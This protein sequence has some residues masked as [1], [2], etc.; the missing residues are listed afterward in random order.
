MGRA[1]RREWLALAVLALPTLLVS[2]DLFVMLLALPRLSADLHAGSTQQLWIMDVYGFMVAGF[3]LT[4]G[5]LGDRTG[6]RR[7]LLIGAAT[8]GAASLL[9]AYATGPEMLIAARALLGFAG[10]A[11]T[12]STLSMV[13]TL[14]GDPRQR[15][16]A[17]GIIVGCFTVGAILG[18]IVGG[19]LL[20]RFWW[21]SVFL[22]GVPVMVLLLVLGPLLLP[23]YRDAA[24]GRL[25][26]PSVA[27]SLA[28]IFPVVYGLKELARGGWQPAPVA[29]I[30]VGLAIGAV[31]V[32]RQL[33]LA[34]P[35]LD[36]RLFTN[37]AFSTAL[38]GMSTYSM[39]SGGTMVLIAQH[40]QLADG[41]SPLG[42]GLALLPGMA[43]AIVSFQIS[44]LLA[45]RMRP[46]RLIAGGLAISVVGLLLVASADSAAPLGVGFVISCLG[47]GP[48][49]TLGTDLVI[50]SAP[51]AKAGAAAGMSQ[52]GN[53]FG[54]S[55]GIAT[56]GSIALALYRT[57]VADHIPAGTPA[58]AATAAR[59]TLTG[60]VSAAHDLPA[61]TA[62]PLLAAARHA[63]T[64]GMHAA[65]AVSAI[66]IAGVAVLVLIH[67]RHVRPLGQTEPAGEVVAVPA[68]GAH[69]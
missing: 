28:A 63:F 5:T 37:R 29:A 49:V 21:G 61:G 10:A 36:L 13:S 8:F 68:E 46:A 19:A 67:L 60:A 33:A 66:V 16:S 48:L 11:I 27:L 22:M 30:A 3:M 56:L 25:D 58:P 9:A 26:L 41:L 20:E 15:A 40:F 42:A 18:P 7:L 32:R 12:P 50:G 44:P 39:L 31:F 62:D 2:M 34:D 43:V 23:E 59:D 65:A 51:A 54:Y 14:F 38:G 24:A 17:I 45:R 35:L 69:A 47:T 6:R 64:T 1:G 53:E 55:L 52:T 4:M 57:E